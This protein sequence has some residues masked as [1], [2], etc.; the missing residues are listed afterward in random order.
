MEAISHHIHRFAHTQWKVSAQGMYTGILLAILEFH[1]P[2][3]TW[4]MILLT[5]TIKSDISLG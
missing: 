4:Y 1:L 5:S 3:I 2:H